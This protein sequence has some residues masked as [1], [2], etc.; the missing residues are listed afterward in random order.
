MA[1]SR[2]PP[3]TYDAI[4]VPELVREGIRAGLTPH[5]RWASNEKSRA[6]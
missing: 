4:E 5:Q 6:I 3:R 2:R 1:K